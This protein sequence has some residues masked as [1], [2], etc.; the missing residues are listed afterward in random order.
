MEYHV[1]LV[2]HPL[3]TVFILVLHR[4]QLVCPVIL[5]KQFS[6]M[7]GFCFFYTT[8]NKAVNMFN[9]LICNCL[10]KVCILC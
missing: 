4:L 2:F 3:Q 8:H 9:Y 7:V 5:K 10:C 6:E 1:K